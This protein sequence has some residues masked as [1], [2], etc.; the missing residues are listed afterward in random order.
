MLVVCILQANNH[1]HGIAQTS[2]KALSREVALYPTDF[3]CGIHVHYKFC[4]AT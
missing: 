3:F 4:E 2:F 1:Q